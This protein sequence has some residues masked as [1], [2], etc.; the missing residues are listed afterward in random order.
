MKSKLRDIAIAASFV[1]AVYGYAFATMS[2]TADVSM[3]E[4]AGVAVHATAEEL[5]NLQNVAAALTDKIRQAESEI[6]EAPANLRPALAEAAVKHDVPVR[7][8]E[9]VAK[10]ESNF[11]PRAVSPV[12]AQGL[13]Q[14]MPITQRHLGVSNP[15]DPSESLDAGAKYLREN[16][17][18][19]K[20]DVALALAAYNA[21]PGNVAKYNGIPPFRETQNYVRTII[22]DYGSYRA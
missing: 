16:L 18:R 19:Y 17:D 10:K 1:G 7:L 13:M 22:R 20:G 5:E 8:L 6:I 2:A 12:G 9:A 3:N 4:T 14:I 11:N 21:G 15:F